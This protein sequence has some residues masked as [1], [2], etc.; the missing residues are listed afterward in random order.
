MN[1]PFR[2]L[3]LVAIT[4][5]NN[6]TYIIYIIFESYIDNKIMDKSSMLITREFSHKLLKNMKP[7]IFITLKFPISH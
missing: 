4:L 1:D 7:I 5:T 6:K 2:V 3:F